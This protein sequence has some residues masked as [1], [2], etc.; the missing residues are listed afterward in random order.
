MTSS[1]G[2][3]TAQKFGYNGKEL[4]DELGLEWYDYGVRNYEPALGRWMNLDPLAEQMRRHSPYNYAFNNPIFFIDPDG[5]SPDWIRREDKSTGTITYEAENGD[6]AW[7]L[8]TQHGEKD[9]FSAEQANDMVVSGTGRENYT[10]ESDGMLMSDVEKGDVL[11]VHTE[12]ESVQVQSSDEVVS[13]ADNSSAEVPQFGVAGDITGANNAVK[14]MAMSLD[15]YEAKGIQE[16][17]YTQVKIAH[18]EIRDEFVLGLDSNASKT[19]S[20]RGTARTTNTKSSSKT[21]S[22]RTKTSVTPKQQTVTVSGAQR[23]VQT[24]SRGGKYYINKNG[25]KTY[26]N[27][28]GTK[29]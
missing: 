3:S 18:S 10:R 8:Y 25:N 4:N 11:S 23:N 17:L 26:L 20:T 19:G 5:M 2:N 29:R 24:G 14:S 9:G 1:L 6:S 22:S 12:Q 21:T 16:Y 7:S 28:D 13:D 27:R 15:V